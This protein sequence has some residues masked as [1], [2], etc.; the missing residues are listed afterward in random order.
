MH[1]EMMTLAR[2]CLKSYPKKPS[3]REIRS[4][5][6]KERISMLAAIFAKHKEAKKKEEEM[7]VMKKKMDVEKLMWTLG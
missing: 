3:K 1:V 6:E 5:N 4:A 7:K 2:E